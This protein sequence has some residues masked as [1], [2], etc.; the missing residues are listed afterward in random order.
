[1]TLYPIPADLIG[2]RRKFRRQSE[3]AFVVVKADKLRPCRC[4]AGDPSSNRRRWAPSYIARSSGGFACALTRVRRH[5]V[6]CSY[7]RL[8]ALLKR[9]SSEVNAERIYRLDAKEE[10][11]WRTQKQRE[12]EQRL[13]SLRWAQNEFSIK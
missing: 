2:F 8:I 9:L 10:P 5:C 3:G 12:C 7:R 13:P 4:V 6:R 1:M 11:T